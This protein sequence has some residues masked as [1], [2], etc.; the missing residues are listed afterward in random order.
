MPQIAPPTTLS[1]V[2]ARPR[3]LPSW[4]TPD[5][6]PLVAMIILEAMDDVGVCESPPS[7]NRGA[8]IDV[9]NTERGAP[10]G[11]YWCASWA[12][13][14]WHRCGAQTA[15]VGLDP[16]CDQLMQWC[17][18]TGRFSKEAALGCLVF[19]GISGDAQ[20]VEILTRRSPYLI[21]TGGNRAW[22]GA[23]SRNGEAVITG[24]VDTG[25]VLGYGH[26]YPLA[27]GGIITA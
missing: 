3:R 7:S 20:H 15:G 16:S 22:G 14:V 6:D 17:I 4:L 19:Y 18:K 27:K 10:L 25:R 1:Y 21:S 26:V 13:A 11:S 9:W 5:V 2:L 12:A 23:F 24:R 8:E